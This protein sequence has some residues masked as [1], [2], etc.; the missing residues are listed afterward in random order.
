[1]TNR[2][3]V[4]A[5]INHEETPRVPYTLGF[6]GDTAEQLDAYLGRTDWRDSL[7]PWI[8]NVGWVDTTQ[9]KDVGD[10]LQRDIFGSTWQEGNI[11]HQVSLAL[12]EPT[13]EGFTWPTADDFCFIPQVPS[14]LDPGRDRF[15]K[16][17]IGWGIFE[18]SWRLCGFENALVNAVLEEDFY[19]ELTRRIAD[20]YVQIIRNVADV[21][22]DA[23]MLG[24]DW[25]DQRGILL[26]ADRWRRFVK[27]HVARLV[28]EVHAQCKKVLFHCCGSYVDILPDIIEIGIDVM[29]SV[30]PEPRGM[31]SFELKKTFGDK[32]TFW[33]CLGSQSTMQFGT[34][35]EIHQRVQALAEGMSKGGG[36]ILAPAKFIQ[37]GT[38]IEN[39]NAAVQAFQ[40]LNP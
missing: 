3:M 24:D 1:M 39:I 28:E 10:G 20:L 13:F 18:Q 25:G 7:V 12:P 26:G 4:M 34:P 8:T 21:D 38:P 19:E 5:A 6:D 27:P 11:S 32:I 15:T 37:P 29:E 2:E 31:D 40:A 14:L 22:A 33:G 36:F 17:Y 35:A 30:Q 9:E 16:I 23:I